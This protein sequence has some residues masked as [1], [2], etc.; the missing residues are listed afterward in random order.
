MEHVTSADGTRIAYE[1]GGDGPPLVLV[2]GTTADHT[3]WEPVQPAL[4]ERFTTL[5]VDRRGRGASGDADDYAIERE[6]EDVAAVCAAVE[7]PVRLF[8]HSYGALCSLGAAPA[9]PDLHRLG[10]YEPPLAVG[11]GPAA[12]PALLDRLD[13]LAATGDREAVLEAFFHDVTDSPE[14]LELY[15]TRPTWPA[16]LAAAL[17]VPRECRAIPGFWPDPEAYADLTVPTRVLLGGETRAA[18]AN[19]TWG[20]ADLFPDAELVSL[21][22]QG[23][24]AID[25]APDLLVETVADFLAG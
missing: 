6:F 4:R 15:R 25:E 3:T 8:G 17:T 23:H 11:D 24:A 12:P 19:A 2:H 5:A 10:L 16:R 1:R 14:R 7:G 9:I 21:P 22:G 18:L 20:A 13:D